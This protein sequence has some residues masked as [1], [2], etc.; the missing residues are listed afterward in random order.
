MTAMMLL[1][2]NSMHKPQH[3]KL[4]IDKQL[5]DDGLQVIDRIVEETENEALRSFQ[6]TCAELLQHA[7]QR[8][9]IAVV[10]A[11]DGNFF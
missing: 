3:D 1:T 2:A 7:L 6:G 9:D 8:R 10:V 11:N 5:V 4:S